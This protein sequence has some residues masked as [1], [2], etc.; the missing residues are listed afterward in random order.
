MKIPN[1]KIELFP[2]QKISVREMEKLERIKKV[3][4]S[5]NVMKTN[6]GILGD[7]PGY[8]KGLSVVALISRNKM[9]WDIKKTYR[10]KEIDPLPYGAF[11]YQIIKRFK[12]VKATLIVVSISLIAQW[13][14]ELEFSDLN[15]HTVVKKTQINTINFEECDVILC[16][17]KI[18]NLF[19]KEYSEIAYKRFVFD[20]ASS[21]HV[22]QMK[23][24]Y[25]G[26][27]WFISATYQNLKILNGRGIHF[28]YNIFAKIDDDVFK[29]ILVKNDDE[30][31]KQSFS[32][33]N[34]KTITYNC[35]NAKVNSVLKGHVNQ[36]TT[37]M[38]AAGNV[39]GAIS[40]LGGKASDC[41]LVA[42]VK[43]NKE[44]DLQRARIS[45]EY[46]FAH[47]DD[48]YYKEAYP[49]WLEKVNKLE[50]EIKE[51]TNR[52]S[53]M[54]TDDCP[55]CQ[56]TMKNT[57]LVPCCQNCFCGL[58]LLTWLEDK[59]TCPMCRGNVEKKNLIYIGENKPL[60][61]VK[62]N[63]I[64]LKPKVEIVCDIIHKNPNGKFIIFSNH[65]IS[66][67]IIKN[68]LNTD[69]K[70]I[71]IKGQQS[72][73]EKKLQQFEKGNVNVLFLNSRYNGAGLNLQFAS[74]IILYHDL[75]VLL[76]KQVIGRCT[77]IGRKEPLNVHRFDE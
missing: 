43:K 12:K 45:L 64:K 52:F 11:T 76:E 30:F 60:N 41:N 65:D 57:V 16:S 27:R 32:M 25:S 10:I 3:V 74:D 35:F 67:S 58:C 69:I 55:I 9:K 50:K 61:I 71:E 8:G 59:K 37:E 14:K 21:T 66:F 20:E 26:F 49:K 62:Q 39:E 22:A 29:A 4:V 38:I 44:N 2:H 70:Y 53:D 42:L 56:D 73:R 36:T 34:V 51:I 46:S 7:L 5:N 75:D 19:I 77:R 1:F 40:L 68:A 63:G 24:C 31:V 23:P 13:K 72:S 15:V 6:I 17:D 28:T 54:L 18:Y 33:P 48:G 47:I